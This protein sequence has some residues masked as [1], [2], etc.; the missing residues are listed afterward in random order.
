MTSNLIESPELLYN[1]TGDE[2]DSDQF[3]LN[4]V[5]SVY[6]ISLKSCHLLVKA[7]LNAPNGLKKILRIQENV[8]IYLSQVKPHTGLPKINMRVWRTLSRKIVKMYG[9][10]LGNEAKTL[11][12]HSRLM[13]DFQFMLY[14]LRIVHVSFLEALLSY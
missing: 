3:Y 11:S 10:K 14:Y 4:M 5:D 8:G 13:F 1:E 12:A 7:H 2:L 9:R 6:L